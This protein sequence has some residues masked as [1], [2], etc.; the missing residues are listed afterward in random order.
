VDAEPDLVKEIT[1]WVREAVDPES[2]RKVLFV[3]RGDDRTRVAEVSRSA[4]GTRDDRG[5][6]ARTLSERDLANLGVSFP[7]YHGL[8][9]TSTVADVRRPLPSHLASPTIG[10]GEVGAER[11]ARE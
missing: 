10:A 3:E 5:E 11:P 2:G 8:C 9:R 7:P 1:P 6:F 4:V